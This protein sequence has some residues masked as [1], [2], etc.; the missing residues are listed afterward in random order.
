MALSRCWG[1]I[2]T[3]TT[4]KANLEQRRSA[5]P[6]E[7]LPRTFCDAVRVA[8]RLG[9]RYLWIGALCIVQDDPDDWNLE[10]ARMYKV[11]SQALVTVAAIASAGGNGG[12][13]RSRLSRHS[14]PVQIP[15]DPSVGDLAGRQGWPAEPLRLYV[16]PR[17]R[18][19]KQ[20][21]DESPL[22]Q[23][24]WVFQER[25]LAARTIHFASE[26]TFWEC[27]EACIGEDY[28]VKTFSVQDSFFHLRDMLVSQA[29]P[30][31]SKIHQQWAFVI[32][33][34]SKRALTKAIDKLPALSGVAQSF[35]QRGLGRYI[36]R[37]WETD[38]HRHWHCH[39]SEKPPISS[40]C[41]I[42]R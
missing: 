13:F 28:E 17:F 6:M 20:Q 4:T 40:R 34:Y 8:R 33:S 36:C 27:K 22:A 39:R 31:L 9:V 42:Y 16:I 30:D 2:I 14:K 25:A 12:C 19:F 21:L 35:R 18:S 37:L 26:L 11:Y 3:T 15:W 41:F 23:R 32:E 7:E 24:A 10:A 38:F 1:D 5:I 29:R